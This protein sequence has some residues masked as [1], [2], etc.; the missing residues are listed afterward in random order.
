[1]GLSRRN[2]SFYFIFPRVSLPTDGSVSSKT[3]LVLRSVSTKLIEDLTLRLSGDVTL[4]TVFPAE[5]NPVSGSYQ[6]TGNTG[7][8]NSHGNLVSVIPRFCYKFPELIIL[9]NVIQKN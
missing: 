5:P 2:V 7:N 8:E 3:K 9:L 6:R 1:M 4:I